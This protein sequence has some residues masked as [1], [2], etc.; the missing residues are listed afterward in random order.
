MYAGILESVRVLKIDEN[1]IIKTFL[2]AFS[3]ETFMMKG[4]T[5]SYL[6]SIDINLRVIE[7]YEP[8]FETW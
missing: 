3:M 4:L 1:M 6:N 8:D 7:N 5:Y 2:T